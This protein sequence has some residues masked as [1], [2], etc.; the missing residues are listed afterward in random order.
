[1]NST[2]Y[3]KDGRKASKA[4]ALASKAEQKA[5]KELLKTAM[6]CLPLTGLVIAVGNM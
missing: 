5:A 3:S 1:M 4:A 2:N 6:I